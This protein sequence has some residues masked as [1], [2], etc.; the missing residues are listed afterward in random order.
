MNRSRD[1]IMQV[2]A[3]NRDRIRSF[4]V[5]TLALFG[6]AAR[7]DART[8]S[9]LDFLVEFDQKTFDNYMGLKEYLESLFGCPVDLVLE[10]ALKPR[11][12]EPILASA[13]HASGL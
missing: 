5:R 13:V 12:R 9:D 6:S 10:S 4:G 1:S 11:L 3:E 7:G 8:D 2:L